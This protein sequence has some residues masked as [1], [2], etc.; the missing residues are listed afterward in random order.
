MRHMLP[1]KYLP[2]LMVIEMIMCSVLWLNAFPAKNGVSDSLSP[3][4]LMTGVP[5][6]YNKHCKHA[7]GTYGQ[8][9]EDATDNTQIAHAVSAICLGPTGNLQ[10]SYKFLNLQTGKKI[11]H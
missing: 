6:D 10:G 9:H 4:L 11:A 3:H 7:F 5:F 8:V 2:V 1:F